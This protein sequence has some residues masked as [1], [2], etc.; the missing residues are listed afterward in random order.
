[1]SYSGSEDD[2]SES[3]DEAFYHVELET[4]DVEPESN[5]FPTMPQPTT[6]A[7][8]FGGGPSSSFGGHSSNISFGGG[9][10]SSFGGGSSASSAPSA[11]I[12]FG[13][14][15]SA[16]QNNFNSFG[17]GSTPHPNRAPQNNFGNSFGGGPTPPHTQ[18]NF[19]NSTPLRQQFGQGLGT[20]NNT[21]GNSMEY[22]N[23]NN[24]DTDTGNDKEN[25]MTMTQD[26][27][28][29][30]AIDSQQKA[31]YKYRRELHLPSFFDLGLKGD[32]RASMRESVRRAVL[33]QSKL[34]E[35]PS[36]S[37][38]GSPNDKKSSLSKNST[39][40]STLDGLANRNTY[41]GVIAALKHVITERATMIRMGFVQQAL[42]LESMEEELTKQANKMKAK[43]EQKM[44]DRVQRKSEERLE[45]KEQDLNRILEKQTRKLKKQHEEELAR[46]L[47]RQ[48]E[49]FSSAI[50][51]AARR[52][53]GMSKVCQCKQQYLCRHNRTS[54]YNTRRPSKNVV[55]YRQNGERLRQA[56]REDESRRWEIKAEELDDKEQREWR[57][58]IAASLIHSPWGANEAAADKMTELHKKQLKEIQLAQHQKFL[59]V[60]Q[61][62]HEK[63]DLM[64]KINLQEIAK[65]RAECKR[66]ALLMFRGLGGAELV[67]KARGDDE[68]DDDEKEDDDNDEEDEDVSARAGR[69]QGA[70]KYRSPG[71]NNKQ[72]SHNRSNRSN[73]NTFSGGEEEDGGGWT[74][75]STQMGY[76]R[77]PH[78]TAYAGAGTG[79]F[80]TSA[81]EGDSAKESAAFT[82]PIRNIRSAGEV[83]SHQ[84]PRAR[85][86]VM[87]STEAAKLMEAE[88][89]SGSVYNVDLNY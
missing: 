87:P 8:S 36:K 42:E 83:P 63:R 74:N 29:N 85:R 21:M 9:P 51:N 34:S 4:A 66:K 5:S 40:A 24:N 37:R 49:D 76:P 81:Y 33:D 19:G 71:S 31:I 62:N 22:N 88:R 86:H 82:S 50:E 25:S 57:D 39:A 16:P 60:K 53:V 47:D 73:N 89:L 45:E 61:S 12:S 1:M 6:G 14:G 59:M 69:R 32:T 77:I 48:E 26:S 20:F 13:G 2:G 23:N 43:V 56:S 58:R 79:T 55:M 11:P 18:N 75:K 84:S 10:S 54:S 28:M 78:T 65:A 17:A 46:L 7:N 70:R 30:E 80:G 67:D 64:H 27:T 52:A 3:A 72:E 35:S 38:N 41:K 15:P 68:D 44:L